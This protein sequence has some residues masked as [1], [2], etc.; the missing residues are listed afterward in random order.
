MTG[1]RP[2]FVFIGDSVTEFWARDRPFFAENGYLGRGVGGET[3]GQIAARFSADVLGVHPLRVHILAGTNDIAE[4]GGPIALA[5]IARNVAGM[6]EAAERAGIGVVIG[7]VPPSDGYPWRPGVAAR[8]KIVALNEMLEHCAGR[9][10]HA[11][12]DYHS[13]MRLPDGSPD[14]ALL[15]DGV[16]PSVL[17]YARMEEVF[18]RALRRPGLGRLRRLAGRALFLRP[19]RQSRFP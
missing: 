14:P 9:A 7:A 1:T 12:V 16:H 3:S 10:G 13:G 19:D 17:G 8:H 18:D 15:P 4:N 5:E 11:F 2:P 6:A